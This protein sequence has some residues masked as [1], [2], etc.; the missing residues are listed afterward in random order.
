[1]Y[2]RLYN[3]L[4]ENNLLY[5]KQFGFHAKHPT[6]HAISTSNRMD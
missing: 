2:S 5:D 6:D 3:Y 1:M 4:C